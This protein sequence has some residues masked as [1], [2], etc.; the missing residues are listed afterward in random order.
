MSITNRPSCDN[1][2][3]LQNP[4]LDRLQAYN[5]VAVEQNNHEKMYVRTTGKST[6][7]QIGEQKLYKFVNILLTKTG[8]N[9]KHYLNKLVV[10]LVSLDNYF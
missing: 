4:P 3:L 1:S 2:A 7:Y 6:D 9:E 5:P 8:G 10:F